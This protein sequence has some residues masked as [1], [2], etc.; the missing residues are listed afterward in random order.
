MST[1]RTE[2]GM[3]VPFFKTL[4]T[5]SKT[6]SLWRP[7]SSGSLLDSFYCE[8]LKCLREREKKCMH[9]YFCAQ[10][11]LLSNNSW[12]LTSESSETKQYVSMSS[13]QL[14]W[15]ADKHQHEKKKKS[16]RLMKRIKF[17]F[18]KANQSPDL[19]YSEMCR[20]ITVVAFGMPPVL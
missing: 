1:S 19:S 10:I 13:L 11:R 8:S 7:N 20:E 3:L 18:S 15:A 17:T 9:T 4:G 5:T 12:C 16:A 2:N 14:Q 6:C